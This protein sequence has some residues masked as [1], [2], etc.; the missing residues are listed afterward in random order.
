MWYWY[1]N[2]HSRQW[3]RIESPGIN[4]NT[5]DQLIFNKGAKNIKWEKDSLFTKWYWENW[6]AACKSIKL[7]HTLTPC[8]KNT[9]KMAKR[10]KHKTR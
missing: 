9:L 1:K 4:P 8:T 6:T 10:L 7:E 2:R 3:N 5:Q